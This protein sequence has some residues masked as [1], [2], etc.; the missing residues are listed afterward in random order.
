MQLSIHEFHRRNLLDIYGEKIKDYVWDLSIILEG[1]FHSYMRL[2][3]LDEHAVN[4][5]RIA[6]FMLN[7]LDDMV[8]TLSSHKEEPL[9]TQETI[10][11]ILKN[12]NICMITDSENIN[13][14]LVQMRDV[15]DDLKDDEDL[16]VS[17]EVLE[18]EIKQDQ[19][20]AA[21]LQGMLSNFKKEPM[22]EDFISRISKLYNL[23]K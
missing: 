2:L 19:P 18:A 5:N 17:L 4:R 6:G 22:F 9:V 12:A 7:R 10:Q 8:E 15:L 3:F 23:E 13:T 11:S 20:R 21:V 16:L 14:I 1:I